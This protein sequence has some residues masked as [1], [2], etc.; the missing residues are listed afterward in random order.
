MK[1]NTEFENKE[2]VEPT[3]EIISERRQVLKLLCNLYNKDYSSMVRNVQEFTLDWE[4][5]PFIVSWDTFTKFSWLTKLFNDVFLDREVIFTR[6]WEKFIGKVWLNRMVK[7][8]YNVKW[9]IIQLPHQVYV[10]DTAWKRVVIL[11]YLEDILTPF[12]RALLVED[13]GMANRMK[14]EKEIMA[15]LIELAKINYSYNVVAWEERLQELFKRYEPLWIK[16]SYVDSEIKIFF[17]WREIED[18]ITH[19]MWLATPMEVSINFNSSCPDSHCWRVI[20]NF[21]HNISWHPCFWNIERQMVELLKNT[22]ID[23]VVDM[24]IKWGMSFNSDDT[25][26]GMT[27]RHPKA[28]LYNTIRDIIC[29]DNCWHECLWITKED[30]ETHKERIKEILTRDTLYEFNSQVCDYFYPVSEDNE[31][32]WEWNT[33]EWTE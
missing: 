2:Y 9:Q 1:T 13:N 22:N 27:W 14:K 10:E 20:W 29:Y 6:D 26:I 33:E 23:S 18:N 11:P 7:T 19:T 12:R 17:P 30:I 25:W 24:T 4:K 32:S 28:L 8:N 3:T 21:S 15:Q 5:I 31:T 16:C